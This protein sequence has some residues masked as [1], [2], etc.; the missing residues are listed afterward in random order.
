MADPTTIAQQI[1]QAG[2]DP[3]GTLVANSRQPPIGRN[4]GKMGHAG[5]GNPRL[6]TPPAEFATSVNSRVTSRHLALTFVV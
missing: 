4:G 1:S 2:V 6:P 5:Y 3:T